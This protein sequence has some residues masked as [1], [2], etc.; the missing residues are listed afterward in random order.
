MAFLVA[1]SAL[2]TSLKP[3]VDRFSLAAGWVLAGLGIAAALISVLSVVVGWMLTWIE[4][5]AAKH[6]QMVSSA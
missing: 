3:I 4:A 5:N 2:V 1:L 6:R